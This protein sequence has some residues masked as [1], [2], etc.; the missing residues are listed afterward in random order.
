MSLLKKIFGKSQ[1][2]ESDKNDS[3]VHSHKN[4]DESNNQEQSPKSGSVRILPRIKVDYSHEI[5]FNDQSKSFMG[6]PMPNEFEIPEDQK[7][8]VKPL[9]EDLILCFAIDEGNNYKI[10]Q[11]NTFKKNPNLN[12]DILH[13]VSLNAL[14]EEI[15]DQ[16]RIN[17]DPNHIIM[18]TAGG[19]F[20]AALILLNNF[21]E[22]L[23]QLLNDNAIVSIPARDLLFICKAGN[24]EA[25]QKL[26]EITKGY[27]D[28]PD[29]QGLLSKALYL[30]EMGTAELKIIEKAF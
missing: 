14:V 11:N 27:F 15:G 25:I 19:N 13:Q 3:S 26:R 9:F 18:V 12:V 1:E 8:I 23:H 28:S 20:E 30:K 4:E 21:W 2:K 7:P 16:I 10:L 22:Q 6:N 5:Y 17:G 24:Q 29:T